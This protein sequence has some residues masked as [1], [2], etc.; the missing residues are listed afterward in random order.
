MRAIAFLQ[1]FHIFCYEYVLTTA[2][3]YE[4]TSVPQQVSK[5]AINFIAILLCVHLTFSQS[6]L[7]VTIIVTAVY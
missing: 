3:P 6:T 4:H 1:E 2:A 5:L 7:D